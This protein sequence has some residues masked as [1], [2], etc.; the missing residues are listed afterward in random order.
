MR[1][2]EEIVI[3]NSVL[4]WFEP[5]VGA[6]DEPDTIVQLAWLTLKIHKGLNVSDAWG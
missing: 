4:S 3:N 2:A 5:F 1:L 6:D